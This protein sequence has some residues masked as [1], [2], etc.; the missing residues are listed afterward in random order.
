MAQTAL[1][2]CWHCDIFNGR[3]NQ[4]C[5]PGSGLYSPL[6][7]SKVIQI[8]KETKS[9]KVNCLYIFRALNK[10]FGLNP[11]TLT[12]RLT[13]PLWP[14]FFTLIQWIL[15]MAASTRIGIF[16]VSFLKYLW[17]FPWKWK[18]KKWCQLS[19][20][21]CKSNRWQ[22]NLNC[23]EMSAIRE[24][25]KILNT[26]SANKKG[27]KGTNIWCWKTKSSLWFFKISFQSDLK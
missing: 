3:Y 17:L 5:Q 25:E 15:T 6:S 7:V 20:S 21:A 9:L 13:W 12:F 24:P 14:C 1:G 10:F 27:E 8:T 16:H 22:N 2:R 23:V 11:L 18:C 26:Q 19:S 4:S